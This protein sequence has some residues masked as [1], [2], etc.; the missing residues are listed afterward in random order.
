MKG[1]LA[2]FGRELAERRLFLLTGIVGLVPLLLPLLPAAP[3]GDAQALRV[4]SA[5]AAALVASVALAL[6][7]GGTVIGT[8][9]SQNRLGF[10]FSRPLPGWAIWLGKIAAAFTLTAAIT[11]LLL[12]PALLVDGLRPMRGIGDMLPLL[13]LAE[14]GNRHGSTL[15]LGSFLI[16]WALVVLA[17]VLVAHT[18]GVMARARS[19]LLGLDIGACC[20]AI[21]LVRR[22]AWRLFRLGAGGAFSLVTIGFLAAGLAALALAGAVQVARGR[23]DLAR[24]HR[25]LSATLWGVLLAA[26]LTAQVY[27]RWVAAATPAELTALHVIAPAPAGRWMAVGGPAAHRLGFEPEFLVDTASR[28]FIPLSPLLARE[29]RFSADGRRAVFLGEETGIA[30]HGVYTVDLTAPEPKPVRSR[31]AFAAPPS[32]FAISPDGER[33]AGF[34]GRRLIAADLSTGRLLATVSLEP[35]L[36]ATED[37]LLFTDPSHLRAYLWEHSLESPGTRILEADLATG[38]SA[39]TGGFR[40]FTSGR[41]DLS[42]DLGRL[43]VQ[44]FRGMEASDAHAPLQAVEAGTGRHLLDFPSRGRSSVLV[45]CLAAGRY[46]ERVLVPGG[47][48]AVALLVLDAGGGELRR[49]AFPAPR[50]VALGGQPDADRL[51]YAVSADG[52]AWTSYLLDVR[53]GGTRLLGDRLAPLSAPPD[54]FRRGERELVRVDI[55]TGAVRVLLRADA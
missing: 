1:F 26:A 15:G 30:G 34:V 14:R 47:G 23:T 51:V 8:D 31:F 5:A 42:A 49:V 28:R 35:S 22:A 6:L 48:R 37:G 2:V 46:A 18:V 38:R 25:L 44:S 24:G 52:K 3:M 7:L 36:S 53:T 39:E 13:S 10:Y 4:S 45:R 29:P 11:L 16:A 40:G 27:M 41:R 19:W 54:L 55:A 43:I 50:F 9:L 21:E 20:L 33:V 32:T 17:L 12:L